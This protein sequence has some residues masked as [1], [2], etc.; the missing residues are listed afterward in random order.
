VQKPAPK[1]APATAPKPVIEPAVV[2][3][4]EA[5]AKPILVQPKPVVEE[6]KQVSKQEAVAAK[7]PA[8][9]NVQQKTEKQPE[10]DAEPVPFFGR[11][12]D[13]PGVKDQSAAESPTRL[14]LF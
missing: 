4:T 1:P 9:A 14:R 6:P 7:T 11:P 13:D 12:P 10:N 8:P 3:K 5:A 2:A